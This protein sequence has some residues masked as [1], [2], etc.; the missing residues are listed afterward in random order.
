M[1]V[2]TIQALKNRIA[3]GQL[4]V[5]L[6]DLCD[7]LRQKNDPLLDEALAFSAQWLQVEKEHALNTIA[8]EA[9]ARIINNITYGL[10]RLCT[11]VMRGEKSQ[12]S[13]LPDPQALSI[14]TQLTGKE[15]DWV[16]KGK[17]AYAAKDYAGAIAAFASAVAENPQEAE[18]LF[19]Q[20]VIQEELGDIQTAI[21]S[22]QKSIAAKSD[23]SQPYNN[24]GVIF[25]QQELWEEA[26][27]HLNKAIQLDPDLATALLNRGFVFYSLEFYPESLADL[28]SCARKGHYLKET[29]ILIGLIEINQGDFQA[30]IDN[31]QRALKI[32]PDNHI[33]YYLWALALF[34]LDRYRESI[35]IMEKSIE[36]NPNYPGSFSLRGMARA[37]VGDYPAALADI[38]AALATNTDDANL[39]FWMGYIK[40]NTGD[41]AGA[42]LAYRSAIEVDPTHKASYANLAQICIENGLYQEALDYLHQAQEID[43]HW[44][45]LPPLIAEAEKKKKGGL[46]GKLFS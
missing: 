38:E 36:L 4:E 28:Q 30:A 29:F 40:K 39:H 18:A 35:D 26:L 1:S 32:H 6:H 31:S 27:Q 2:E 17:N 43:P 45:A 37:L 9:Y 41:P 8:Y 19:Y 12:E 10:L 34:N 16:K 15:S 44:E 23:Y 7:F 11:Q 3:E 14:A 42:V 13:L 33:A 46:W 20:G 22:Y 21:E 25:V 5:P 24:L